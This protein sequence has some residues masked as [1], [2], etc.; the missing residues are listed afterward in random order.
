[1]KRTYAGTWTALITPFKEDG[2][3]D[4]TALRAMVRRQIEGGVTGVLPLGTTGESPCFSEKEG[5]RVF[6]IVKEEAG[7]DV[8]VMAGTGSNCTASAVEH[9]KIAKE[10]GVDLCLVVSPYYNKP[11]QEGLRQHFL[12]VAEVGLP[13]CVYNIK[14]RTGVNIE[15][16]TLMELAKHEN[17]IAVKEASGDLEQMKEVIERR[18]DDFTVLSGDDGLTLDLIKMGGDGVVSVSSNILP[19]KVSE[20]VEYALLGNEEEAG[21]I[22]DHLSQMFEELFVETNPIPA[23]YVMHKMG[24]CGLVFRLPMTPPS[25]KAVEILDELIRTYNLV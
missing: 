10:V 19:D 3:L 24:L 8:M 16:D 18:P 23:K 15:T 22:N 13:V 21:K 9:T 11:T 1:M 17:I 25:E 6:E 12:A 4:E 20:M 7:S 5:R 14:G 2:S